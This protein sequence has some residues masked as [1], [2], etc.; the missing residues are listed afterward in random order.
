LKTSEGWQDYTADFS[1]F[2]VGFR[3]HEYGRAARGEPRNIK[4]DDGNAVALRLTD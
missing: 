3:P 2:L 4:L 1:G